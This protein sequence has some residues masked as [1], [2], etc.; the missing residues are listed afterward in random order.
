MGLSFTNLHYF[1]TDNLSRIDPDEQIRQ[2][3]CQLNGE[4]KEGWQVVAPTPSSR[5]IYFEMYGGTAKP[6]LVEG[7]AFEARNE[8]TGKNLRK[9]KRSNK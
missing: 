8:M 3:I 2:F 9:V 5:V 4:L 6:E 1:K 7:S